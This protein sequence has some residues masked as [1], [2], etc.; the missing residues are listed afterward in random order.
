MKQVVLITG[1]S[2]GMGKSA[3]HILNK[4][5]YNVYAAARRTE[6]MED[7]KESGINVI[8]LD[9]TSE[10]S[11]VEAVNAIIDQD[12]KIDIL[13]NNAGYGSYGAVEDVPLN[14]ARRQFEVN[15]FGMA[16]LTQLVLPSMRMSNSGRIVNISSMGGKMYTPMGAW[17]HATKHAVEGW[18]DCLR[19]ELKAFGIDVV[20][21]EP[22]GIKTPWGTIAADNLRETSGKGVYAAFANQVA[23]SMEINYTG[24]R[25]TDVDVLGKTIAQ[26]ATD[27]KP[28]TRYVKGYMAKPALAIRKWFGDRV[29]DKMIMSQFK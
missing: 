4:Q 18:S 21:V 15:L 27:P 20:V 16:R 12:G 22:G 19:L 29:F 14:E 1:A 26:A 24:D 6:K 25:L 17:Y 28:K 3:A 7:L 2:S 8:S 11:M 9:L 13:I 10:R 23:D 5:G